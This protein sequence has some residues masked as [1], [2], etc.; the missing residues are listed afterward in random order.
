MSRKKTVDPDRPLQ[1][2]DWVT[3]HPV[4]LHGTETALNR[5]LMKCRVVYIHPRYRYHVVE[6]DGFRESFFG[7]RRVQPY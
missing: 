6:F 1:V 4:T 5:K 3:R 7:V 2:G